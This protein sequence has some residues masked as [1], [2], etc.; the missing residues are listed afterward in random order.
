MPPSCS[1]R[2][3]T[4]GPAFAPGP[5]HR[6]FVSG[7]RLIAAIALVAVPAIAT[8]A[9]APKP[10]AAQM[11][12]SAD[13]HIK[14][15]LTNPYATVFDMKLQP[16]DTTMFHRHLRDMVTVVITGDSLMVQRTDRAPDTVAVQPGE[17]TYTAYSEGPLVHRLA[18]ADTVPFRQIM[19][20]LG[21]RS[22]ATGQGLT[23][24]PGY[25]LQVDSPRVAIYTLSLPP[26]QTV[27]VHT[28]GRPTLIIPITPGTLESTTA[29]GAA[30]VLALQPGGVE[31]HDAAERRSLVNTGVLP[32][33]AVAIQIK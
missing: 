32:F 6:R 27:P 18:D 7:L 10:A 17:A 22:D 16:G 19:V 3:G 24:V 8:L 4:P 1:P 11:A 29:G 2:S 13:P 26:G 23:G 33:Q 21:F 20:E 5:A 25:T 15:V 9:A 12:L 28:F 14:P 30:R 31:W